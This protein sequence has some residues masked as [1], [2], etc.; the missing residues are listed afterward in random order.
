M[1]YINTN[2]H[3]G[4]NLDELESSLYCFF[5]AI[6][7]LDEIKIML[8]HDP[9]G[10]LSLRAAAAKELIRDGMGPIRAK[11]SEFHN[12]YTRAPRKPDTYS[13]YSYLSN[14]TVS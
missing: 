5:A 6:D 2:I 8:S 4:I 14:D 10:E 12:E 7:H 9:T 3:L 13:T 1:G 11:I